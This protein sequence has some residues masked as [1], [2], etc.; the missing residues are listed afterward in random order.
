MFEYSTFTGS[1]YGGGGTTKKTKALKSTRLKT[2]EPYVN[3]FVAPQEAA[4]IDLQSLYNVA[5]ANVAKALHGALP[6]T[7]PEIREEAKHLGTRIRAQKTIERAIVEPLLK[8]KRPSEPTKEE[9]QA[10]RESIR[11]L[12][13]LP[14]TE[15]EITGQ[16]QIKETLKLLEKMER[17]SMRPMGEVA[18][19]EPTVPTVVPSVPVTPGGPRPQPIIRYQPVPYYIG[20]G[21]YTG[22]LTTGGEPEGEW[23]ENIDWWQVAIFGGLAL[24]VIIALF[25]GRKKK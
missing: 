20:G 10:V 22:D 15:Y 16:K 11:T 6:K 5:Q 21:Y 12:K 8:G 19:T 7:M 17:E 2:V 13:T 18:V 9:I 14:R 1:V 4:L 23:W 25:K 24:I 3:L